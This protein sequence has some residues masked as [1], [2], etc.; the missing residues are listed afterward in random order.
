[1]K[2]HLLVSALALSMAAPFASAAGFSDNFNA[3]LSGWTLLGDVAA[4]NGVVALTSA[5]ATYEDDIGLVLN[6]SGNDPLEAGLPGG[7]EQSL[8]LAFGALDGGI[9][10]Q[11]TEGSAL[12]RSV[13]VSAGDRLSFD[14]MLSTMDTAGAGF[15]LDYAFVVIGGQRFDLGTAAQADVPGA[16]YAMQT[17][18][19]RFDYVFTTGGTVSLGIGVVD[20]FDYTA[21][22]QLQLDNFSITAVPEPEAH[23]LMLAGLGLLGAV[24]RRRRA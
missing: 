19:S 16:P 4:G 22:T 3:G 14:W 1:M 21:S 20:V 13:Q 5:S 10:S 2:K 24:A 18:W 8:G 6:L 11:A 15:G 9:L 23:A 17:G 12:L 7:L